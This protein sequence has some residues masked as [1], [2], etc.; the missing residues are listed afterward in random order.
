L[1][2]LKKIKKK[3]TNG[4]NIIPIKTSLSGKK[5]GLVTNPNYTHKGVVDYTYVNNKK[6]VGIMKHSLTNKNNIMGD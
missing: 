2:S 3:D 6:K 4:Q 5:F 1:L